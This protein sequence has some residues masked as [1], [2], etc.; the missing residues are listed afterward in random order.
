MIGYMENKNEILNNYYENFFHE[1]YYSGV[2]GKG[3]SYI[4]RSLEKYWTNKDPDSI[5]EVGAG[6]GE[7]FE[8]VEIE[9]VNEPIHYVAVD[10]NNRDFTTMHT[11]KKMKLNWVN[12]NVEKLP[13]QSNLFNRCISTCL[14]LHLDNPFQAFNELRRV[15]KNGGEI[16]IA[17]PTD[18]GVM[19]RS[20][21]SLI[22]K[23]RAKKIGL[24][25]YD[26]IS[27]LEHR[28]HIGGLL[29][30]QNY[31]FRN[32]QIKN[33]YLPFQIPSWNANILVIS[34]IKVVK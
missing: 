7:H 6:T 17:Y 33:H 4:H 14:F 10:L 2:Q 11:R 5:L 15:V 23:R 29:K 31:V 22:T 32:D 13:F 21:K 16:A 25:D 27:S 18:P 3:S 19:N 24:R 9:K 28:N 20:I 34:H 8:F 12:A 26:L 1:L 30:M